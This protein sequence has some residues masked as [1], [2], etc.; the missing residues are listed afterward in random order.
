MAA[1]SDKTVQVFDM[2][3]GRCARVMNDVHTRAVHH[4][5]QNYVSSSLCL[6]HHSVVNKK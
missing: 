4:I 6:S 5:A 1:G 3:A 2:N